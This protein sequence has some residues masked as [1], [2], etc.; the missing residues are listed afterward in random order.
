MQN[1]WNHLSFVNISRTLAIDTSIE[2]SSRLLQHGNLKICN[3]FPKKIWN[4]N[5]DLC[6]I[7]EITLAS[8]ISVVHWP[9]I[10]Q[11]KGL[12][13]YY[14]METQKFEKV[15][16]SNFDLCWIAEITLASLISVVHWQLIHQ[17]KGLHKYCTMEN[18]KF[19][20]FL[21]KKFKIEFWLVLTSWNYIS[22]VNISPTLVIY[23]SMERSSRVLQHAHG[24]P[25]MWIS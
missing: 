21:Q 13:E 10:H 2:R 24:N 7:A 8:S 22:F 12:H 3:F 6:W 25:R 19:D 15:R 9:L 4:S 20:F 23:T 1:S 16:N 17:W 14:S 18:Q 5:F 11:W